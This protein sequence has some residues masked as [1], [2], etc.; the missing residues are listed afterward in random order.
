M[1]SPPSSPAP[2]SGENRFNPGF[3]D[4]INKA[5]D[6]VEAATDAAALVTVG[7]GKF[8]S[9][10]LDLEWIA[11][12]G[13]EGMAFVNYEFN[14]LL[15]RLLTFPVVTVAAI[16]GHAFAGGC[17]LAMSHDYRI[18][19]TDRGFLC[20][21]EIDLPSPLAPGMAALLR[22]SGGPSRGNG[23]HAGCMADVNGTTAT[24]VRRVQRQ[25]GAAD[26]ARLPPPWQALHRWSVRLGRGP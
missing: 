16:N 20:M 15:K 14:G 12:H 6:V 17:L 8:F 26:A 4:G 10:G 9:N 21:N 25:D 22:Y 11:A 1:L 13:D 2:Q 18:M 5:L 7:E 19:R 3:V 24:L 23:V